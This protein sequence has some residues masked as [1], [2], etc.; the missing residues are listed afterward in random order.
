VTDV[1]RCCLVGVGTQGIGTATSILVRA[2]HNEGYDVIFMDKK[3][4][5]IRGGSVVSQVVYNISKQPITAI[6]PYGKADLLIGIDILEAARTIDPQGRTRIAS[7]Q[8]TGAVINTDKFPTIRGL[9]AQEDFDVDELE[10]IVRRHTRREDYLGRN[11]SRICEEYLGSKIYANIMMLGFAFQKGL[12]PVS[13]HSMAWAIKDTIRAEF[14]KNLYAFNMGRKLVEQRDLFQGPPRRT[15]WR[16]R[17]DEKCRHAIRRYRAGQRLADELRQLVAAAADALA[18]L[19]ESLKGDLVV[20]AYDCMRWG[21]MKYARQ[22]VEAVLEVFGKDRAEY[23]Y[24]ATRAVLHNLAGAMLIKDGIFLAE[25]A[26]SPEKYFRDRRKYNVNPANGDRIVYRRHWHFDLRIWPWPWTAR[27]HLVMRDRT[28]KVLKRMRW[29]RKVLPGWH[30]RDRRFRERYRRLVAE[31]AYASREQYDRQVALL[32]SPQCMNCMTP[33][34][35]DAGCPLANRIPE[36]IDLTGQDRWQ[37]ALD[38]LHETNNFP[39]LTARVCPAPCQTACKQGLKGYPVQIKQIAQ[40]IV[41]RGFAEGW[42]QP[43]NRAGHEVTVFERDE[44]PGGLLRTGIPG[45]R[46]DR[47][48]LDRRLDQ[49]KAEGVSF[50]AGVRVGRDIAGAELKERFDAVLLATGALKPRDLKVPGRQKEGI[51]FALDYL[52]Q[53]NLRPGGVYRSE[54]QAIHAKGKAVVVI[55]GG[56][57]GTDC[58]EVALAQGAREVHQLEILEESSTNHDP[59][60]RRPD[61]VD[62][63]YCVATREFLGIDRVN[64]LVAAEVRWMQ[65]ANG[66]KMIEVPDSRFHLSADLVL[67]ALGF[68]A[69]VDAGLAEQLGLAI[70]ESGRA[71]TYDY[72]TSVEG[73]FAAGDAVSGASLVVTAIHSGRKA[74]EKINWYLTL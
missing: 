19:D 35:R 11:I 20:R 73:V 49:L 36:W 63:R 65:T 74:A 30:R 46:L 14:R 5:A 72:A 17:L 67:L 41:E 12:I 70:D 55:G 34:C 62:R 60:Q 21:G 9:M 53:E 4:L 52:R 28:L 15:A 40:E 3:G 7:R 42:I 38:R 56:E 43:V 69:E 44:A 37:E 64:E 71:V 8:R 22:Y 57:T 23:G 50:Q 26:T 61:N 32:G 66:K 25:L 39:E 54:P 68:D 2:A 29:V 10:R 18:P 13:M 24:A 31:L 16:D 1:W 58:A 51:H 59:T 47:R 48:L 27:A 45:F 33:R 6:I